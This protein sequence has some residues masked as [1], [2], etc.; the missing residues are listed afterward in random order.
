MPCT[1]ILTCAL[2]L[3]ILCLHSQYSEVYTVCWANQ[4]LYMNNQ[5]NI[6]YFPPKL[7]LFGQMSYF[8]LQ[9]GGEKVACLLD[10]YGQTDL[11]RLASILWHCKKIQSQ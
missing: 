2:A 8:V 6:T 3:V 7:S 11:E 4:Q 9:S 10:L 5:N 1:F